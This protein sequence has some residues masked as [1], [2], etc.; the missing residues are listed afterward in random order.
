MENL[1]R[2]SGLP[3]S[4]PG[5]SLKIAPCASDSARWDKESGPDA[6]TFAVLALGALGMA[7]LLSLLS[8][9]HI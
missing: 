8:L 3:A 9:I 7:A 6:R 5:N 4:I 1:M 2:D